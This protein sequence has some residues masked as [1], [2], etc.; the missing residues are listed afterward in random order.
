M[1]D[2]I[3]IIAPQT[4]CPRTHPPRPHAQRKGPAMADDRPW[5]QPLSDINEFL[6]RPLFEHPA[7]AAPARRQ[8]SSSPVRRQGKT[9]TEIEEDWRKNPVAGWGGGWAYGVDRQRH[10]QPAQRSHGPGRRT[11]RARSHGQRAWWGAVS[12]TTCNTPIPA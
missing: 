5:W 1:I 2:M 8:Q 7:N 4:H 6:S 10:L 12:E 11:P 3:D 9:N